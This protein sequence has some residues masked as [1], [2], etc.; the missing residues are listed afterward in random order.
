M[1]VICMVAVLA[2]IG[3]N[4]AFRS[5]E[6]L[7]GK[8]LVEGPTKYLVDFSEAVKKLD[9]L[10]KASFKSKLVDKDDCAKDGK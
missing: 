5:Y 4:G 1:N 3:S 7:K 10:E 2:A 6:Q 9:I 8:L